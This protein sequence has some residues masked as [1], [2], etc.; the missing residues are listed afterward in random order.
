M[1]AVWG[2]LSSCPPLLIPNGVWFPFCETLH[3]RKDTRCVLQVFRQIFIEGYLKT[4]VNFL[5][6]NLWVLLV[7]AINLEEDD[8]DTLG[9]SD[10]AKDEWEEKIWTGKVSNPMANAGNNSPP[11]PLDQNQPFSK[12]M[13]NISRPS[14]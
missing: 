14:D 13:K 6:P 7:S 1:Y 10:F 9:T 2:R 4:G 11:F 12:L 3:R 8:L 5:L